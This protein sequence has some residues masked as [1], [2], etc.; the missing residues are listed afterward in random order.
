[1]SDSP[2]S[3]QSSVEHSDSE[4]IGVLESQLE[5][6]ILKVR[7]LS[8]ENVALREVVLGILGAPLVVKRR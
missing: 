3:N 1:M 8:L 6:L 5:I 2:V 4:R 7:L